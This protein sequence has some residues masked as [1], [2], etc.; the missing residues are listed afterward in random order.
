LIAVTENGCVDSF[1]TIVKPNYIY[2]DQ[3]PIV[4]DVF[5]PNGDGINDRFDI[6]IRNEEKYHLLVVDRAGNTVFES[7]E[8]ENTWDGTNIHTGEV[9]PATTYIM[10]F[11]YKIKGFDE[12]KVKGTIDIKR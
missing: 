6:G 1:V 12:Q 3:K 2:T 5:T 8:K 7:F 11:V 9:C 4:P 10:V